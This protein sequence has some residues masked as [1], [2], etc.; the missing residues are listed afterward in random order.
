MNLALNEKSSP[1]LYIGFKSKPNGIQ[2]KANFGLDEASHTT[3]HFP[4]WTSSTTLSCKPT[5]RPSPDAVMPLGTVISD[6]ATS[7]QEKSLDLEIFKNGLHVVVEPP[8]PY[9]TIRDYLRAWLRTK[10]EDLFF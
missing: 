7:R 9:I 10:E 5:T 1:L 2:A 3:E 4:R 6:R 8:T